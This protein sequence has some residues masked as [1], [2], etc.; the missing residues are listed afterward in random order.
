MW[1][2][3]Q[4]LILASKSASRRA[5]LAAA[6]IPHD[7]VPAD[8]DERKIESDAGQMHPQ[9]AALLLARS[10]AES[11]ARVHS[12]RLVLGADQTLALGAKRF[13]KPDTILAARAQLAALSGQTHH[14]YSAIALYKDKV[15]IFSEVA[16]A[17]LD[18]RSLSTEF[19]D[20]YLKEAGSAI[21]ASVGAYQLEALGIHLFEKV[22]GDHSTILGLPMMPLLAAL[23]DGGWLAR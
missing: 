2:G 21:L 23:R 8:L 11:V 19:I 13:S 16:A 18:M 7:V 12:G 9:E 15:C 10:K 5:L 4:P 3:P 20:S 17:R 14:L 1:L 22:E 6:H